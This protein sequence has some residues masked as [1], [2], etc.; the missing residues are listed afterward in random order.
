MP[1]TITEFY[2]NYSAIIGKD[3]LKTLFAHSAAALKTVDPFAYSHC[4][5]II[6]PHSDRI[7][8]P[9]NSA[10]FTEM[11]TI[12]GENAFSI[13]ATLV[14]TQHQLCATN[15]VSSQYGR[16]SKVGAAKDVLRFFI[17]MAF[18]SGINAVTSSVVQDQRAFE[19]FKKASFGFMMA[20][21]RFLDAALREGW[22]IEN[23]KKHLQLSKSQC[24][25]RL[26]T[27]IAIIDFNDTES[28]RPVFETL[29]IS[30][31][32]RCLR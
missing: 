9:S 7:G 27:K 21:S 23:I 2:D 18:H 10:L 22:P 32:A 24:E 31:A 11:L 12:Q 8:M 15:L 20:D 30:E 6:A 3:G 29:Q 19:F 17:E 4:A 28:Y 16:W 14:K 26:P 1:A 13:S 25:T 5:R